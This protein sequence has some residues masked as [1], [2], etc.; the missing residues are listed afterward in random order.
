M[1]DNVDNFNAATN[2]MDENADGD[3]GF[4]QGRV[5]GNTIV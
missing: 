2:E 5:G 4:L 3:R 1:N